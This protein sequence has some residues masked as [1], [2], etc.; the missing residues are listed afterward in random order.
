MKPIS[1]KTRDSVFIYSKE[2]KSCRQIAKLLDIHYSTVA[3][4]IAGERWHRPDF[5][6]PHDGRPR[7]LSERQERKIATLLSSG[8]CKNA[9]AVKKHFKDE[10]DVDVSVDVVRLAV[11]RNE[12]L[13]R[14]TFAQAS[15]REYYKHKGEPLRSRYIRSTLKHGGGS[16]MAWGCVTSHGVGNLCRIDG[17][18]DS[19]LYTNILNEEYLGSLD[20]YEIKKSQVI[21]QQDNDPKHTSKVTREW[22]RNKRIDVLEWPSQSPDLNIMEHMWSELKRGLNYYQRLPKNKNELWERIEKE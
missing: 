6:R 16:L 10:Y 3:R 17:G 11:R 14:V 22:L 21:F 9:P 1:N 2:G 20:Y 12:L 5:K 18:L 8:Q 4:V 13:T 15:G 19:V 7:I